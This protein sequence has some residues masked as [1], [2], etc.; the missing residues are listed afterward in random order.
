[1]TDDFKFLALPQAVDIAMTSR[2]VA[3]HRRDTL[4]AFELKLMP[5]IL[6]LSPTSHNGGRSVVCHHFRLM[7]YCTPAW[8]AIS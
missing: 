3:G 6:L 7:L 1:M 4:P 8:V 2:R 5:L